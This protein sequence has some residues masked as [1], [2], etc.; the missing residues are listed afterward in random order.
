MKM[1]HEI[2]I[3]LVPHCSTA[4]RALVGGEIMQSIMTQIMVTMMLWLLLQYCTSI[5]LTVGM[6]LSS[7]P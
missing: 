2:M 7:D 3:A 5:S 1:S 6:C 4:V